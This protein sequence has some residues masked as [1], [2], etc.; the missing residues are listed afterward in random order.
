MKVSI[1]VPIYNVRQYL[2]RCLTSLLNQTYRNLEIILVNDGSTDGSEQLIKVYNDNRITLVNKT[3]G[4]L[5]SARNAGL[6]ICTGEYITFVDSDDWIDLNMIEVMVSYAIHTNSDIVVV[7]EKV[8]YGNK[9]NKRLLKHEKLNI[10]KDNECFSQLCST[11]I[12]SYSWGKLYRKALWDNVRFPECL[13]Y[14]DIA[15]SYQVF[16]K[17]KILAVSNFVGY[18]YF[19]RNDSI[20][21]TKR[22]VEVC[23][24]IHHIK[25]MENFHVVNKYW[26]YY[27][28]KL[29]YGAIVYLYQLHNLLRTKD[30]INCLHEIKI[31][32]R[33]IKLDYPILFYWKC[34]SFYKVLLL[35]LNLTDLLLLKNKL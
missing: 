5:S 22:F 18:Y 27:K 8:T 31:L 12:P 13:N 3:N 4:G 9:E 32:K 2:N 33:N 17:C 14:E 1:I 34:P 16:Y 28:L 19:M 23:S 7:K 21:H 20:V 11:T 24:I 25:Q 6:E 29:L 35:K 10:Y 15:T 26:G 30:F